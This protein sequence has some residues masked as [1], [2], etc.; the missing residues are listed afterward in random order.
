MY[1]E[2]LSFKTDGKIRCFHDKEQLK[3]FTTTKP[4]LQRILKD[5]LDRHRKKQLSK[6][7]KSGKVNNQQQKDTMSRVNQYISV[8]TINVNG[9]NSAVKTNRLAEWVKKQH[10]TIC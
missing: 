7:N 4:I 6:A 1:P 10:L 9:L 2:K 3:N 8:L 5:V